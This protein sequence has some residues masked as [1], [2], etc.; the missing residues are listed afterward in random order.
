MSVLKNSY[1]VNS[2]GFAILA[3]VSVTALQPAL[4]QAQDVRPAT[5]ASTTPTVLKPIVIRGA[6]DN[7]PATATIGQPAAAFSGG[8]VSTEAR[9]GALGN[10]PIKDTPFSITAYTAKLIR[11]QQARTVADITLNDP[12]VRADAPPF[13]ERDSFLIRGFPVVNLDIFYDGLPYIAN[14]RRHFLEGI[15]QV[16]VLKGPSNFVNGG[17]GRVGGTINLI[18]K[19]AGDEPLTRLTTGYRSDSQLWTHADVGR[20][21]GEGDEWG[22]RANGSFRGGETTLDHNDTRIGVASLGIDYRGEDFRASLDFS[23]S[24]QKLDSPTSLFNSASAG[25]SAIPRAPNGRINT[26][27]PFEYLDSSYNMVAGRLE[28]DVLDNTTI[29]AAVG[30]S[31]YREDFLT[32]SYTILNSNGDASVAFGYN[33]QEIIGYSGETGIRS[34]FET[35]EIEHKLNASLSVSL[36]QNNRGYFNPSALG[37]P[38]YTTNI[39]DPTYLPSGSVNTSGLPRSNNLGRFAELLATSLSLSDTASLF[40]DRLEL[41]IGG[42]YQDVRSE[43]FNTRPAAGPAGFRNYLYQEARFSP[44]LAATYKLQDNVSLYANY[45]EALTEGA[46][47]PATA[48]NAGQIFPPFVNKQKEIGLKYDTGSTMLTAALFEIRQASGF[49]T[50]GVFGVNGL[51][52]NRGLELTAYGEPSDGVRL[53][54]GVTFLDAELARTNGGTFNGKRAAGVPEISISLYGEYDLPWVEGLTATGRFVY[55][56]STYYNQANTQKVDD[57]TRV[58]LGARYKFEREN[59]KAIELRANV[60][61]V[62]N[63]NYWASSARGWLAAGAART[64]M[65]SASFD[66]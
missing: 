35:G 11:D 8:Q 54:G 64:F 49:T 22:I 45:V 14:P 2:Y 34:E 39:Y 16:Q 19:R 15:E 1:G 7:K 46:I 30:A 24:T 33:P 47:A 37:F 26:A 32:S 18:P 12:S 50:N 60:E 13:S 48:S 52:I 44:A 6:R 23:H 5:N 27:N 28:Y 40:D 29:Y 56:G 42:R 9:L 66:F 41:T 53:L 65:V 10:R 3:S 62:L 38:T 63:E 59:G 51:Q 17:I 57:W 61:N 36:N 21:F 58:D 43:G 31:R 25:L 20:R 55:S 4:A